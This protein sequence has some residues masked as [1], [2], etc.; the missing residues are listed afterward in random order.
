MERG[1]KKIKPR[2]GEKGANVDIVLRLNKKHLTYFPKTV[3]VLF[4]ALP[5]NNGNKKIKGTFHCERLSMHSSLYKWIFMMCWKYL[6]LVVTQRKHAEHVHI[7]YR[8]RW[9]LHKYSCVTVELIIFQMLIRY[10]D[11]LIFLSSV[12]LSVYFQWTSVR[13]HPGTVCQ[14]VV[15]PPS[16]WVSAN[17][18]CA[19]VCVSST[20]GNIKGRQY[21]YQ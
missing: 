3:S 5:R 21:P 2:R 11:K 13:W 15:A 7:V 8:I 4:T 14:S 10:D 20:E 9:N 17:T 12:P 18:V 6:K 16:A 19:S 1:Q